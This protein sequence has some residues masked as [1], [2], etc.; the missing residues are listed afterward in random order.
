[1]GGRRTFRP[2]PP[3]RPDIAALLAGETGNQGRKDRMSEPS[4]H[5]WAGSYRVGDRQD[6]GI[7]M[8]MRPVEES[9]GQPRVG[10]LE[11]RKIV[12]PRVDIGELPDRPKLFFFFLMLRRLSSVCR[13]RF[14]Q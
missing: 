11:S 12:F 4:R 6:C 9:L 3:P 7:R 5:G 8:V 13:P 1:M 10:N 2:P 14:M